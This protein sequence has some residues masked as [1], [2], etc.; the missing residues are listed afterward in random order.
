MKHPQ[1]R[2]AAI[3]AKAQT[4]LAALVDQLMSAAALT[5]HLTPQRGQVACKSTAPMTQKAL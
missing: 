4:S 2:L 5:S 1:A 3:A